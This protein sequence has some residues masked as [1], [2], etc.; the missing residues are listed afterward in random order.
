LLRAGQEV[1]F[2]VAVGRDAYVGI[3]TVDADGAILQ[4]FPNEFESDN[5]VKANQ[6]RVVPDSSRQKYA[7]EATPTKAGGIEQYR[8]V[9]STKRWDQ[10][11]GQREGP[12]LVFKE[13]AAKER[14]D[15]HLRSII[16]QAKPQ[17][18]GGPDEPGLAEEIVSY[19]V[20]PQ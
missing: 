12:Y 9:A 2:R 13:K 8:V 4:L 5:F 19:R 6:P 10:L 17:A 1:S 11:V 3:W 18:G 7:M 20:R 14:W 15:R 16:L